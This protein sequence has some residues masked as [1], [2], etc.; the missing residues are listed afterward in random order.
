MPELPEVETVKC[1]IENTLLHKQIKT[2]VL[3]RQKIRLDIPSHFNQ[4]IE[5]AQIIEVKRRS[6]YIIIT[7]SNNYSIV[8]HLGMSGRV[9]IHENVPDI[10]KHDHWV[11]T[12]DDHYTLIFN[13]PRRF[14]VLDIVKTDDLHTH[15]LLKSIGPEPFSNSFSVDYLYDSLSHKKAP[16]KSSL[17]DQR[18]IAGIG[19]IYACEALFRSGISPF[20]KSNSLT[21]EEVMRLHT[22]IKDTL[23]EAIQ[24]GGSTLKDF[25]H[26][27]GSL[28]YFQH[29]F[30]VY[31]REN[32]P[33]PDCTCNG[34]A[35]IQREIQSGRSTY[36]CPI[37]QK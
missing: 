37:K 2:S 34:K 23:Q 26:T 14:G 24:A 17:L 18:L 28:G 29:R 22:E 1:A 12:F 20:R 19:N 25:H 5:G 9:Y 13:D 15:P 10:K 4:C 30:K 33:C 3:N 31:D 7:L 21:V 16:I 8:L 32:T 35:V 6:K 36:Y 11:C 27:D